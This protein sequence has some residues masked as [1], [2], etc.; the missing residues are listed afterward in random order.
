[1]QE[2]LL[3]STLYHSYVLQEDGDLEEQVLTEYKA[4]SLSSAPAFTHVTTGQEALEAIQSR[5]FDLVLVADHLPDMDIRSFGQQVR[6][7]LPRQPLVILAFH[8]RGLERLRSLVGPEGYNALF[9]WNG[10][11]RMLLAVIKTIEDRANV[12][13]DIAE[14]DVGV[15]L[16]MEDSPSRA[17]NLL[18]A[19]YPA[20][21]RQSQ[22][23]FSEGLNRVQKLIRMRTR[24]KV[25]H[26]SSFE[27]AKALFERYEENVLA[28]IGE[29]GFESGGAH[30]PEAGIRL[31]RLARARRED[32]PV[33][34]QSSEDAQ[35][36]RSR[37]VAT[38]TVDRRS[39]R[40]MAE[41]R[42]FLIDYLGFGDFVFRL[43]DGREV[44]RARDVSELRAILGAI[45]DES[46]AFHASRN[47][48]SI[49]L[50]AR[51]EFSLARRLKRV[52]VSD[53]SD[54]DG[55]R[56]FL[57]KEL[58]ALQ[59]RQRVGVIRDADPDSLDPDSLF[60]RIGSGSLG[61]KARGIAFL[62]QLLSGDDVE[63]SLHG[64]PLRIPQSFAI[65]VEAFQEF[66]EAN[67]LEEVLSRS[68][69]D[70]EVLARFTEGRLPDWVMRSLK[71]VLTRARYPLA[72]RSSSLLEDNLLHPFAGIYGT[73][74]LPNS[75]PD[76]QTRLD[77]LELA[78][79]YV[80][81]TT[82]F[83][84]ARAYI[85]NTSRPI[86]E[87]AMGVLIQQLVGQR[88]GDRFYPH[89]AGVAQSFNYYPIPPQMDADGVAQLVL[90][91]GV[92]VVQGGKSLR[93]S[94]RY[95][96]QIPGFGKP[97]Q[98]LEASQDSFY[99]LDL[100]RRL[101]PRS[102]AF[103]GN[104]VRLPLQVAREDGT[105][106]AV[107]SVY[108]AANDRIVEEAGRDGPWL[109][110][111]NNLLVHN[112]LPLAP[113]LVS[114]LDICKDAMGTHVEIELACDMGD[115][116]R[117]R[118]RGTPAAALRGATLYLLQVRPSVVRDVVE[119]P[120]MRQ[121]DPARIF[122]RSTMALG[123][124]SYDD[125][126]DIVYVRRDRFDPSRTPRIAVEVGELN[127][128]LGLEGRRFMLLGPGRW[129]SSDSWLGVP[130]QWA[131]IAHAAIIVEAS[132][133]SYHVDPSQGAH[134]FHNITA[135]GIGYLTVPPGATAA[136]P[137]DGSFVDWGW[138]DGQPAHLET[139]HLR[140][141]RLPRPMEAFV[142]GR[143]G[144]GLV[145]WS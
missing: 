98:M 13:S 27:D 21:M 8:N 136:A 111:F 39:S 48:I 70:E 106:K 135:L 63:P 82:Y 105:L 85:A 44:G 56:A 130:V 6:A 51:S 36:Q 5:R 87:E 50:M 42:K 97:K 35:L 141:L 58:D 18:S 3:V 2:V 124:G 4:L 11:A 16:L 47:H 55:V 66:V 121:V 120:R 65:T 88:Y 72:V 92:M 107:G 15:I 101:D 10:D 118:P 40:H 46:L 24:P 9:V 52:A 129:G 1:M 131:Q 109:V 64:L 80:F 83:Q 71:G 126:Q 57:M 104:P 93:F 117:R 112:A 133:A 28:L 37:E 122:C 25:L 103:D 22:S 94:P 99:A 77:E 23:L 144:V 79:K 34:L 137:I 145:A 31:T 78:V 108:D 12:D 17:S 29:V 134:F 102:P 33:L 30:D 140:L 116:G 76:D 125:L 59:R 68:C 19:L 95:P 91:F 128:Q 53:F 132:P 75:A 41:I 115:W 90:G 54:I 62:D 81:A 69:P 74:M 89:F 60:Q 7:V 20:L 38:V 100:T 142:N 143:E 96:N 43:P 26:A 119:D 32:L 14:A 61:G 84:N 86:E 113:A 123:H 110:T 73:A 139:E 49:W 127:K 114:L 67:H 45:P 138:L